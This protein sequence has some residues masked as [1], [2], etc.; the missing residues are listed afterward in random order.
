MTHESH[1]IILVM[2]KSCWTFDIWWLGFVAKYYMVFYTLVVFSR[3][4]EHDKCFEHRQSPSTL[5]SCAQVYTNSFKIEG[6]VALDLINVFIAQN[7]GF[8]LCSRI[9]LLLPRDKVEFF[10]GFS[11]RSCNNFVFYSQQYGIMGTKQR[12]IE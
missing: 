3:T 11:V 1:K 10:L 2:S 5:S 12:Q 7:N 6:G 4:Q 9:F 8:P